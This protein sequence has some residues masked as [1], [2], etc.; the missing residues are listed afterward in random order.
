MALKDALQKEV[1][2]NGAG[3][4]AVSC[5]KCNKTVFDRTAVPVS[6]Y[7]VNEIQSEALIHREQV[8]HNDFDVAVQSESSVQATQFTIRM[9]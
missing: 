3:S 4:I 5:S 7:T 2:L 1:G 6:D 8:G 9:G